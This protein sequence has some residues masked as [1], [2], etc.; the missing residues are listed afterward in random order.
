[1]AAGGVVGCFYESKKFER[2]KRVGNQSGFCNLLQNLV[3]V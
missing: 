3:V 2:D 1:V